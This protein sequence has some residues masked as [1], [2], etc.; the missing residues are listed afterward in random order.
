MDLL[1]QIV[2][3]AKAEKHRMFLPK[4]KGKRP[5]KPA[6]KVLVDDLADF[7]SIGNL[8]LIKIS[9]PTGQGRSPYAIFCWKKKTD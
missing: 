1:Q 8:F 3:R 5:L 7:I 6:E 4:A 9:D 2:A